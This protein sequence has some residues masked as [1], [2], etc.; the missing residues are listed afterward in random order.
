VNEILREYLANYTAFYVYL[1]AII[2]LLITFGMLATKGK[3]VEQVE[4]ESDD[5]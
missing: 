2:V 4:E 1:A 3:K 5:T